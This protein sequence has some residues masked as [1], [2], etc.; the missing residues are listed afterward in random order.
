MIFGKWYKLSFINFSNQLPHRHFVHIVRLIIKCTYVAD[1]QDKEDKHDLSCGWLII[2]KSIVSFPFVNTSINIC[3]MFLVFL[4]IYLNIACSAIWIIAQAQCT[5]NSKM[6]IYCFSVWIAIILLTRH[7][8]IN[9]QNCYNST[10]HTVLTAGKGYHI[11][12]SHVF[13]LIKIK[14][15]I[16]N[17]IK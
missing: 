9:T 5:Y 10:A 17:R 13:A 8:N 7:D 15:D 11:S 14:I 16:S 2:K 1:V 3:V 12:P 4:H 6:I